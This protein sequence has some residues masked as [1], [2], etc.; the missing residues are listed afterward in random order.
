MRANTLLMF[1]GVEL[2][3]P[4]TLLNESSSLASLRATFN[5]V[6]QFMFSQVIFFY[7]RLL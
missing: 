1:S 3:C 4:L 7:D 2:I 5:L 6:L